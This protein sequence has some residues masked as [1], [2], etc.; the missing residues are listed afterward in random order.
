MRMYDVEAGRYHVTHPMFFHVFPL[1]QV[2]LPG[3]NFSA[4]RHSIQFL[5]LTFSQPSIDQLFITKSKKSLSI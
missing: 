2:W 3:D 4:D 5:I 1:E